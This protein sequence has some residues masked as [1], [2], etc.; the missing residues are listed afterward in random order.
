MRVISG[1]YKGRILNGFEIVGTRA[2]MSRVRESLF[3]MINTRLQDAVCLD[4]F[5]GTGSL[6][7]EALS[8]GARE[9]YFN[10]ANIKAVKIIKENL[11]M[12][13]V[14]D[15]HI[16][17]LDYKKALKK[18]EDQKLFFDIVFIDPPYDMLI[19]D[20]LLDKLI[21]I[22][23]DKAII[24]CEILSK[25]KPQDNDKYTLIKSRKYGDKQ[26]LIYE[27]R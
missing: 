14:K 8:N 2:T 25:Y 19:I 22:L 10:D 7:I 18:Y 1:K 17:N 16:L 11:N 6:G 15:Q 4:L 12:L 27:K 20:E 5:A 3:A 9:L 26:L 13:E 21:D 23:A 24:V